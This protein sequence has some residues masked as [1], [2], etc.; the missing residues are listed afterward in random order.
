MVQPSYLPLDE[1]NL[2]DD[3][4]KLEGKGESARILDNLLRYKEE[5]ELSRCQLKEEDNTMRNSNV[6]QS[7]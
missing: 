7:A 3:L 1:L 5:K 6:G 4:A 2:L